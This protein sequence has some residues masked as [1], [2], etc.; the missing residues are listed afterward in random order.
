MLL[1]RALGIELVETI[2]RLE[3]ALQEEIGKPVHQFLEIDVLRGVRSIARI[4]NVFHFGRPI[5]SVELSPRHPARG[6]SRIPG[7]GCFAILGEEP[8]LFAPADAL[9]SPQPLKN[10][11]RSADLDPGLILCVDS[12]RFEMLKQT[13]NLLE[14]S[15]Q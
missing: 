2:L 1:P 14:L 10:E 5:R 7:F 8:T 6:L 3:A 12:Q 4:T 13:L 15:K 11:L 9:V